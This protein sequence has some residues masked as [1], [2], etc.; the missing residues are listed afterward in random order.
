MSGHRR[1]RIVAQ[2]AVD[3]ERAAGDGIIV[4]PLLSRMWFDGAVEA[5]AGSAHHAALGIRVVRRSF[6]TLVVALDWKAAG[7]E[8]RLHVHAD[9]YD[10]RPPRGWWVDEGGAPLRAGQVPVGGGFQPP[11]N[12]YGEDRSWLCFPGWREYHDHYSHQDNPW[13][14]LRRR[15]EYGLSGLLVQ[16]RDDLNGRRVTAP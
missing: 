12:P 14:A 7:R 15:E 2:L 13:Q 8:I 5:V 6:P 9:N 4:D 3:G 10:Y 1:V 16:L 11:P